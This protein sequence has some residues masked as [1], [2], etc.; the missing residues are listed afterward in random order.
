M[1]RDMKA[2]RM[3]VNHE[4]DQFVQPP[5]PTEIVC[6]N[7]KVGPDGIKLINPG[8][9]TETSEPAIMLDDLQFIQHLG[10]GAHGTVSLHKHR[11]TGMKF[12]VKEI[13]LHNKEDNAKKMVASEINNVFQASNPYLI[14]LYNGFLRNNT[15]C[16][17][18]E[19]MDRGNL[20]E[21]L[22]IVQGH[23]MPEPV[24]SYLA[25]QLLHAL[26]VLHQKEVQ[27]VDNEA[28]RK[29][30]QIHRDIKP[31]NILISTS[32]DIKLSDFG[33]VAKAE[34]IGVS[35]FVGT[36]T[37]MSPERIKGSTYGP[38][39][40]VWAAGL[41]IAQVLRGA[42]PFES[43]NRSGFMGLLK[44]IT[45]LQ[46]LQLPPTCSPAAQNF[47]DSCLRQEPDARSTAECLLQHEWI[48]RFETEGR[49]MFLEWI[50]RQRAPH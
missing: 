22:E 39:S 19:Y 27:L 20:E 33:I 10:K 12:A 28:A 40:D 21:L 23:T 14:K 4:P 13:S 31:G 37:Y 7:I 17:V 42:Y 30:R 9:T 2:P 45:S 46:Q 38:P 1:K 34:T 50:A 18:M 49:N 26:K 3:R 29:T 16:L 36:A 8:R 47:V 32:G 48:L 25:S 24:A 11:T 35:S 43:A 44:E 41:V 6:G 5:V 15:L